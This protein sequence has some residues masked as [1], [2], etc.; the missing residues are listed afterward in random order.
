MRVL[1]PK[2]KTNEKLQEI[3][4]E[5]LMEQRI[6]SPLPKTW[7]RGKDAIGHVYMSVDIIKSVKKAGFAPFD[8]MALSDHRGL[9]FDIDSSMLFDEQMHNTEPAKLRKLQSSNMKRVREYHKMI[10]REWETH[11]IETRLQKIADTIKRDGMTDENLTRL[12]NIDQQLTDIMR[13]SEKK[14]TAMSKHTRDP[15]SPKLKEI[16]R[17]IRYL[18]VQIRHTLRDLL[19]VSVVECMVEVTKL[20]TTLATKRKEYREFIKTAE[21]HRKMHLDER[22]NY[23]VEI[24][25]K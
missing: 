17:E 23:H 5:N 2:K 8:I 10:Q 3:G 12:N 16:A 11:K 13:F 7:N 21:E 25:K 14:C 15:W 4:L 22:A 19:P 6:E 20:H 9:F 24:G 1:I 18:M